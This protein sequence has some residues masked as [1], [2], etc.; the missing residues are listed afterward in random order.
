MPMNKESGSHHL[1]DL[2]RKIKPLKKLLTKRTT[3]LR[4]KR[5]RV[6]NAKWTSLTYEGEYAYDFCD[7]KAPK[8]CK[9]LQLTAIVFNEMQTGGTVGH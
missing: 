8:K 6:K 2:D 9:S 7:L 1:S 5:Y 4:L 3:K